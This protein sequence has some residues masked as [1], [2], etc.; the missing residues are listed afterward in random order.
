MGKVLFRNYDLVDGIYSNMDKYK[1]VAEFLK[2][3]QKKNKIKNRIKRK[4]ALLLAIAHPEEV[5][6]KTWDSNDLQDP[7]ENINYKNEEAVPIPISPAEISPFGLN[8]SIIPKADLEGKPTSNLYYG[9]LESHQ[10]AAKDHKL[11]KID[12]NKGNKPN[13]NIKAIKHKAMNKKLNKLLINYMGKIAQHSPKTISE[14]IRHQDR[15]TVPAS[16]SKE[17]MEL[18]EELLKVLEPEKA[19]KIEK[20]K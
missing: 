7:Y 14:R 1:N 17:E 6:G 20:D 3:K 4:T 9:V 15:P 19:P 10:F 12:N 5:K 13:T 18:Y 16:E 2:K 8:D 11:D